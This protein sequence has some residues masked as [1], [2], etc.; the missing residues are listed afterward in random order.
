MENILLE[1]VVTSSRYDSGNWLGIEENHEKSQN[2]IVSAEI[3]TEYLPNA[4][5]E[6]YRYIILFLEW[7]IVNMVMILSFHKKVWK[8]LIGRINLFLFIC[9]LF[10]DA[11]SISDYSSSNDRKIHE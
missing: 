4:N 6:R 3:R 10:R 9:D 8:F 11:V 7:A 2:S 5:L 1:A